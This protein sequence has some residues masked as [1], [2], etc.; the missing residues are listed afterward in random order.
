MSNK[1]KVY[2]AVV[3]VIVTAAV[4]A[5]LL[6]AGVPA[7]AS[8]SACGSSCTSPYNQSQGSGEVL[9]VSGTSVVLS[10]AST[11]N[12][13]EDWT[14]EQ[15]GDVANAVSAGV[16]SAKLSMLYSTDPLVEYQYAPLGVPSDECL[17]DSYTGPTTG[18]TPDFNAP[19][20]SVVTAQCGITAASLWIVDASNEANGYV[21]LINA[22]YAAS[23]G[24]LAENSNADVSNLTSPFAEPAVLTVN[25]SGKVVL[26]F[27]SEIG[28]VVSSTQ[29]WADWSASAEAALRAATKK[30]ARE[31]SR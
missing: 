29:M 28:G 22:G 4:P 5:S 8:T 7:G 18:T 24:Y 27:L 31:S 1:A 11:S 17:A 16:V 6:S 30:S 23:F 10:A 26:A 2:L 13:A 15:E 3:A 12:S 20:L 9:A 25:S 19:N 21:D 14:P